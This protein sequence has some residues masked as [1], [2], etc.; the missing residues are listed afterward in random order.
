MVKAR[1]AKTTGNQK[2]KGFK[3]NRDSRVS[4]SESRRLKRIAERNAA[5][6]CFVCREKGHSAKDCLKSGGT[7]EGNQ[8][9]SLGICY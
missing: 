7:E 8:K 5:T 4:A 9:R 3:R 6:T 2:K 1:P